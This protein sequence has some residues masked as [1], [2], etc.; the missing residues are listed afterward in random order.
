[1][2]ERGSAHPRARATHHVAHPRGHTRHGVNISPRSRDTNSSASPRAHL[3]S[4]S[5][6]GVVSVTSTHRRPA[7]RVPTCTI[8]RTGT[9]SVSRD[10]RTPVAANDTPNVATPNA[11]LAPALIAPLRSHSTRSGNKRTVAFLP[12]I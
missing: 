5:P 10:C 7:F 3:N 12:A 8:D 2:G 9:I 1:M 6:P 4:T 11:A